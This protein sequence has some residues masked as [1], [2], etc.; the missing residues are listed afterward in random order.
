MPS[1]VSLSHGEAHAIVIG[2]CCNMSLRR[3]GYALLIM[4]PWLHFDAARFW[5][6]DLAG[7]LAVL[8][9]GLETAAHETFVAQLQQKQN[10]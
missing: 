9:Q 4:S 3:Q 10:Q 5:Q 8:Q 1:P 6:R 2:G 7:L